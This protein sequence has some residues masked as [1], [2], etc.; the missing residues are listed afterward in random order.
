LAAFLAGAFFA[1][2]FGFD[3]FLAAAGF[4]VAVDLG[5]FGVVAF[6]TFGLTAFFV[7]AFLTPAGLAAPVFLAFTCFGFALT[8][9]ADLGVALERDLAALAIL[10]FFGLAAVVVAEAAAGAAGVAVVVAELLVL[11]AVATFLAG[12]DPADFERARFFVPVEALLDD[13][14]FFC[15]C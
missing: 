14:V 6:L 12:F 10:T 9:L 7:V 3:T 8:A 15:F 2:V 5:F 1:A 11:A 13:D 4:L